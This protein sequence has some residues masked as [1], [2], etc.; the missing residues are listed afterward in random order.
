MLEASMQ[1]LAKDQ[2][3]MLQPVSKL[4]GAVIRARGCESRGNCQR[5]K[6]M[7]KK[8]PRTPEAGGGD[9][10]AKR[11]NHVDVNQHLRDLMA[12]SQ[13]C[14]DHPRIRIPTPPVSSEEDLSDREEVAPVDSKFMHV[15]NGSEFEDLEVVPL[16][17]KV[18]VTLSPSL[19]FA[20]SFFFT[21][22]SLGV[23]IFADLLALEVVLTKETPGTLEALRRTL[24]VSQTPATE[25]PRMSLEVLLT[26]DA[27]GLGMST[28]TFVTLQTPTK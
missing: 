27:E 7:A 6:T 8:R 13:A 2:E 25:E 14:Y 20:G 5:V 22:P 16:A 26:L 4:M 12:E 19:L 9:E 1:V 17:R 3:K 18:R 15:S 24:E 23:E 28:P 21:P 11:P 10:A